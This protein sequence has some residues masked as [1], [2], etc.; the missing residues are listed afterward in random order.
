MCVTSI[1]HKLITRD[2]E[3][4]KRVYQQQ[5]KMTR[6]IA[7]VVGI[8]NY[9]NFTNTDQLQ[10]A[11]NDATAVADIL[12]RD[13]G[14]EICPSGSPLLDQE[15]RRDAIQQAVT[16]SLNTDNPAMRWLFYFSGHGVGGTALTGA[17]LPVDA[18]R[19]DATTFLD[20]R[21]LLQQV[22][23]S[24][25]LE[26]L[27]ILDACY[28]GRA[29]VQPAELS[30]LI[31]A[32]GDDRVRQLLTSGNP[33][34]PV[35]D[36]GGGGHSIFTRSLLDAL[37]GWAGI[38]D[39]DGAIRFTRLLDYL[40][41]EIPARLNAQ[42]LGS[43]RQQPIGGNLAGNH[44]GRN[45]L[46]ESI[47]PRLDPTIVLDI[48]SDDPARRQAGLTQLAQP[49]PDQPQLRSQA[50]TLALRHLKPPT[51][52]LQGTVDAESVVEVRARAATTLGELG[53]VVALDALITALEDEPPVTRAV[54]RALTRLR[55]PQATQP[56]LSRLPTAPD[57]LLLD[58]GT[59]LGSIGDPAAMIQLLRE[60]LRRG[61]LVPFIGPDFPFTLTGLR[62]RVT[63]AR[64]L[65]QRWQQSENASLAEVAASTITGSD[66]RH[67]FTAFM[68]NALN[69]QPITP[70]SIYQQLA[71]LRI[72]GWISGTYDDL[73]VR[74]LGAKSNTVVS[75]SDTVYLR[76]DRPW[77]IRLVGTLSRPESLV[78]LESD[79]TQLRP[80]AHDRQLLVNYL[81]RECQQKVVLF[82][83]HDPHSPD[84][85]L[86]VR[87]ILN[88]HLDGIE[89]LPILVWPEMGP[90]H[91][92]GGH[93][94]YLLRQDADDL[95]R[96]LTNTS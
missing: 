32:D 62:D 33:D 25:C 6:Q 37:E 60:A 57:D 43:I 26:A 10:N 56:L 89:L 5:S 1:P 3:V 51:K 22:R 80:D 31:P 28:A 2:A 53:D 36:G 81:Q 94:I 11:C 55:S 23:A 39:D 41:L 14:F 8:D 84:F 71:K 19:G 87:H 47:T 77:V 29:L 49:Y 13:Y 66:N 45:F 70:G 44:S 85:T 67:T 69:D 75:G 86:L 30:D 74:V 82:L 40:V 48:R 59:A 83:G 72:K 42:G 90:E 63:V 46:L 7:V 9:T 15:A 76:T 21:T 65:A 73:L 64:D 95:V 24:S 54:V 17:L 68:R 92:W 35:L 93:A 91:A 38:H 12:V 88:R 20:L 34:Q 18:R 4:L 78:V 96:Q 58:L 50:V 27:I 61:R 16:E 79:Y 52:P